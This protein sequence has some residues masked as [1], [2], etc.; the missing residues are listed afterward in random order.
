MTDF[1]GRCNIAGFDAQSYINNHKQ[2]ASALPNIAIAASGG[3]YRALLNGAG[4]VKAF[5]SR[6]EN[7]TTPGHLGGLLQSSTYLAGL[8]GGGWLVGS[9]VVNNFSTIT[10]LQNTA[11]GSLWELGNSIFK[12][13]DKGSIQLLDSAQYFDNVADTVNDKTDAGFN[14]SV[15]DYWVC[16]AK[17]YNLSTESRPR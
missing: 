6:E 4:A 1:L 17:S 10:A 15:T 8:S 12:G 5:D 2:N 11:S 14:T 3:G 16:I 13:P 7:S 9:I